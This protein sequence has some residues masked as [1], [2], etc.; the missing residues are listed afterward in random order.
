MN[1]STLLLLASLIL[2]FNSSPTHG[3][4]CSTT[5]EPHFS[6]YNSVSGDGVNITTSVTMVST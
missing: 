3:Q 6:V 5:L 4:G 1:R 2:L